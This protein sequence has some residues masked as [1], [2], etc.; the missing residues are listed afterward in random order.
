MVSVLQPTYSVT[1]GNQQW[2]EQALHVEA[3]LGAAPQL[4]SLT[5][6]FPSTAPLSASVGDPAEI[7]L[8]SGE[9]E[10]KVFTGTIASVRR[11]F[12]QIRVHALNAGGVLARY[13]PAATYEKVTAATII[14]NLAGDAGADTGS[15]DEGVQL[16]FY[17]ADPSRT[18]LEH[19]ARVAAWSGALARVSEENKI[20]TVVV[21]ATQPEIALRYGRELLSLHHSVQAAPVE[22]F[23]VAGESGAGSTSAPEAMRLKTDFFAGNRPDGPSLGNVWRWEPALRTAQ[24]A[25]TAGAARQRLYTSQRERGVFT[26]FLLPHLRPGTIIE[27]QDMPEGLPAGP[28]WIGSVQHRVGPSGAFT[29]AQFQK[30]GD[31]F[32][33]L[34]LLGSLAGALF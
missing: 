16:A 14:R 11:S 30:G 26:A 12:D 28:L 27:I 19:L 4:D 31:S 33:P 2:T 21:N 1:F 32:D 13:R 15:I 24:A 18:A 6:R 9:K 3:R 22:S 29:R 34:A 5:V 23:V 25:A 7:T 17:V 10:S 8:N 20:E